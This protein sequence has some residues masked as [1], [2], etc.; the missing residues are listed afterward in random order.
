LSHEA[1]ISEQFAKL[2]SILPPESK[3]DLE[4]PEADESS[5]SVEMSVQNCRRGKNLFDGIIKFLIG[6]HGRNPHDRGL[7]IATA[8]DWEFNLPGWMILLVFIQRP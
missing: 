6:K 2:Q 5:G 8:S 1:S 4:R 7:V 3:P